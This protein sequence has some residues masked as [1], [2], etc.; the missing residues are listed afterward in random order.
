MINKTAIILFCDDFRINDNP[1]LHNICKNYNNIIPLYIYQ[2]DYL[3][4]PLGAASKVFLH[5]VLNSFKSLLYDQYKANL[6]I[7]RG[8]AIEILKEIITQIDI[9]GIYFNHSYTTQQIETEKLIFETFKH[10]DIKSFK[11]KLLFEPWQIKSGQKEYFKVFTPFSKEC[12]KNLNLIEDFFSKP[13]GITADINIESILID[14]LNLLPRDQGLWHQKLLENYTFDYDQIK[15]NFIN[16]INEKLENYSLERNIPSCNATS[17]ISPYLRFGMLS[18]KFCFDIA[19]KAANGNSQFLLEILWREFAYHVMFYNQNIA[20]QE[21]KEQYKYFQFDNSEA[22]LKKWQKG[23]TGYKMV[24]AGMKELYNNGIMH[25]RI[26]MITASFLIK[27]LL[28]DW[29]K[30]EQ[31]FWDTLVDADPASNPFSWQWVFGSG[32]DGAPY[33]RIFN[34]DSQREKFDPN[35]DYCNKWLPKNWNCTKIVDHD[36][37]RKI[38]LEKYS[39]I[40]KKNIYD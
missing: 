25:N 5:G 17:N 18:A 29:K 3:G 26:R 7:K 38:T 12:L 37:Q 27:D 39:L 28:I 4:R 8:N 40:M 34:P 33:F 2:E 32:F 22:F 21:L 19:Y 24:D 31:W 11:A 13:N 15:N 6:I 30:G 14:D 1:A 35:N 36:I 20:T 23:E 9:A 10:L 16:F